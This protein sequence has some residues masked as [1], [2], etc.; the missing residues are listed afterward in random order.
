M[1]YTKKKSNLIPDGQTLKGNTRR[2][3]ERWKKNMKNEESKQ[4]QQ[5]TITPDDA[6]VPHQHTHTHTPV[7]TKQLMF[8][9]CKHKTQNQFS[10]HRLE[11]NR[12]I[13]IML[14][15]LF[16]Y[17]CSS[18]FLLL[19]FVPTFSSFVL[20]SRCSFIQKPA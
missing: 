7:A 3:G 13:S 14:L 16:F 6:K 19:C 8:V 5:H 1:M 20:L 9:C 12:Q 11:T 2:R 4:Q 10:A 18:V 15:G 17:S